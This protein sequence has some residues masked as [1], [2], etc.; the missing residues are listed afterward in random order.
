MWCGKTWCKKFLWVSRL[1]ATSS[2]RLSEK[3]NRQRYHPFVQSMSLLIQWRLDGLPLLWVAFCSWL[4]WWYHS[5]LSV[6]HLPT[7]CHQEATSYVWILS[8]INQSN[9]KKQL[10]I[11]RHF[12]LRTNESIFREVIL[13]QHC[14]Q[15]CPWL[16]IEACASNLPPI[17]KTMKEAGFWGTCSGAS[18]K[19]KLELLIWQFFEPDM[20]DFLKM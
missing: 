11:F 9:I 1:R 3:N 6:P 8:K 5:I 16:V 15:F 2:C 18:W 4:L 10:L 13:N 17:Q 14:A 20:Q 19:P 7:L 12:F